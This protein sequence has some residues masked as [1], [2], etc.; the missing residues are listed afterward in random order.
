MD[1]KSGMFFYDSKG[2]RLGSDDLRPIPLFKGMEITIHGHDG[3]FK[4]KSWSYHHGHP[5]EECGLK[6]ILERRATIKMPATI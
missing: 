1:T 5:D 2:E 4:V 3:T 6:V